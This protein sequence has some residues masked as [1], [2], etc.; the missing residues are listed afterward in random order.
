MRRPGV[1]PVLTVAT[2]GP[3]SASAIG[4]DAGCEIAPARNT[5]R[6]TTMDD[7]TE[8]ADLER[9]ISE[10]GWHILRDEQVGAGYVVEFQQGSYTEYHPGAET[11]SSQ[12]VDRNDAYRR[13][14]DELGAGRLASGS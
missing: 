9:R 12:G 4:V 10:A 5:R 11:R 3:V 8:R 13:F 7:D 14:L 1:S 6:E 2:G